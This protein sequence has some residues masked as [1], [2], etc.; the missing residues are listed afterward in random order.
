MEAYARRC[1]ASYLTS[2]LAPCV[3]KIL[4]GR[5]ACEV[6]LS[7]CTDHLLLTSYFLLLTSY[8][9]RLT[10]YF[11]QVDPSKCTD[12]AELRRNFIVLISA[13]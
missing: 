5:T 12:A 9:L 11:L 13:N 2:T 3:R 4:D 8:F 6:D 10:S 1:A 7:K